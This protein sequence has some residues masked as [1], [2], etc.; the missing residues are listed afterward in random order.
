MRINTKKTFRK[1]LIKINSVQAKFL[2]WIIPI[3]TLFLIIMFTTLYLRQRSER[4]TQIE[5]NSKELIKVGSGQID[6]WLESMKMELHQVAI[7]NIVKTGEWE[8]MKDAFIIIADERKDDYGFLVFIEKD[9]TYYTTI[10]GKKALN[11]NGTPKTLSDKQYFKEIFNEGLEFSVSNPYK[12]V[13]NG[14]GIFIIVLPVKNDEGEIMGAVGGVV[15]LSR[16]SEI[17]QEIKIGNDGYGWVIDNTG[18]ITAH[19]DTS[20]ILNLNLLTSNDMGFKGLEELGQKMLNSETGSGFISI[21][22]GATK[23]VVYSTIPNTSNWKLGVSIPNDYIFGQLKSLLIQFIVFLAITI[24]IS[25]I[26]IWI[27]TKNIVSKPLK[28]LINYTTAISEGHLYNQINFNTE[29]EVGLMAKS[30]SSMSHKIREIVQTIRDNA[31]HISES[32][33]QLN[34]AANQI[35]QGANEQASSSEEISASM[36]QMV[37]AFNQNTENAQLT[38][39]IAISAAS[40]I[41]QVSDATKKSV[42]SVREIAQ[43][44]KIVGDI[45][46][47]TDL[48]AIN[49]A[50]E[51]ARAGEYGKGF[52]VV[53]SEVRKLAE[54]SQKAAN[55]I[56]ELSTLSLKVTEDAGKLMEA[57]IPDIMKN[58]E[59]VREISE[60]SIEQNSGA[61]QINDAIQ[62]FSQVTQQNA[63]SA[64]QLATGSDELSSQAQVLKDTV[65]YFKIN[66]EDLN[67]VNQIFEM[68]EK[69]NA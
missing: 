3:L 26:I 28:S 8:K 58:A 22:S 62:Q 36:E 20:Y 54:Y 15:Y 18:L 5:E 14:K 45:A 51:A 29:D 4:V 67:S 23:F 24:F 53:A 64:E 69:H 12:S 2:V 27:L 37:A 33:Q 52:A 57:I 35:A 59:L 13:T 56:I 30:L 7:R 50:V 17:A 60:A 68:I 61:N 1:K 11:E 21:P 43:K 9:G 41:E 47:K 55:E 44:I 66:K 6:F 34:D 25:I 42:M 32:S 40:N 46:E 48:L 49:A 19:A 10:D 38:E 16:L 63:A 65:S 39:Q 31:N